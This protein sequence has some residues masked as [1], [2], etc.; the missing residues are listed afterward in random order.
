MHTV[1]LAYS[2]KNSVFAAAM[3]VFFSVEG[4]N[5]QVTA[6]QVTLID[7]FFDS[8]EW[9]TTDKNPKV[10]EIPYGQLMHSLNMRERWTYK[11]SVTTPPCKTAVY[12]NVLRTV[13][14]IKQK[15]LDQFKA[16]LARN[17]EQK[18]KT[19]AETGNWRVIQK[20][21][22]AHNAQ[23]VEAP[24]VTKTSGST[25]SS[26]S[27]SAS[28]TSSGSGS[29][30]SS[31]ASTPASVANGVALGTIIVQHQG[32]VSSGQAAPAYAPA[33]QTA[34]APPTYVQAYQQPVA[35]SVEIPSDFRVVVIF[36]AVAVLLLILVIV[37]GIFCNY[38]AR[39]Y[40]PH[41]QYAAASKEP[42][43]EM[44]SVR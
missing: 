6:D 41:Q 21:T 31:S 38:Y 7:K 10:A 14:P 17:T 34:P 29:T 37:I 23:I 42:D 44:R 26:G 33:G 8:L 18:P 24:A 30:T 28:S 4:Y 25:A 3:G 12:W 20:T 36:L 40:A 27:G 39:F 13:Y 19:L 9:G 22:A 35:A 32:Y 5:Q 43:V 1:H 16:Q 15:H 2:E 11:G